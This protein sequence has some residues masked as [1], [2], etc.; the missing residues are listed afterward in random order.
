[1]SEK[2]KKKIEKAIEK[3]EK[4]NEVLEDEKYPQS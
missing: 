1:M 3:F 4:R 2:R